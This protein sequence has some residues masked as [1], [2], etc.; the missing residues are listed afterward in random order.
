[1]AVELK[2]SLKWEKK[3][4]DMRECEGCGD[5]IL[6]DMYRINMFVGGKRKG[7]IMTFCKYCFDEIQDFND[8]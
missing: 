4:T 8:E 2:I 7:N 1:M 5:M 6:S 3:E